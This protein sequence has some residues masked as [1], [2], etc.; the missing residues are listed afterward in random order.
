VGTAFLNALLKG[1]WK[2][3][4][5]GKKG[6]RCEQLMDDHKGIRCYCELKEETLVLTS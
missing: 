3:I 1:R 2:N 6:N 4:S 5:E